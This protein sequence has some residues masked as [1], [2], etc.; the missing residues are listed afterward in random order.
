[1]L[2][3]NG[4]YC[5]AEQGAVAIFSIFCQVHLN[6]DVKH[7]STLADDSRINRLKLRQQHLLMPQMQI[8]PLLYPR[9]G[10]NSCSINCQYQVLVLD[11][12]GLLF[13]GKDF[14]GNNSNGW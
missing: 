6:D 13:L 2:S 3:K 4:Y 7:S 12:R 1:M 11:C 10:E 14:S 8:T 5:Q 9:F